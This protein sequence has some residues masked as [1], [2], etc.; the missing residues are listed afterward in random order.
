MKEGSPKMIKV[1]TVFGTRPEAIKLAPIVKILE[2]SPDTFS[3]VCCVTAQHREMLDQ[4]LN[5]FGVKP[6]YDL[7]I[8]KQGQSLTDVTVEVL[9]NVG[10][11]ISS[12][13]PDIV[14]VQGDTTTTFATSLAAFYQKIKI[15]HIEAGLRTFDKYQPFPEEI[16]RKLTA[17]LAD[18]HFAPT[19]RAKE[20][21]IK[22][23]IG[24]DRI[25]ITGNTGIDALF[26][27]LAQ[28]REGARKSTLPEGLLSGLGN[29][30]LILVTAHRR[31]NFGENIEEI[32]KALL[33]IVK[34]K[35]DV[36]IL[37][38]VHFNPNIRLT[39]KQCLRGQERIRLIDPLEYSAF[40]ELLGKAYLIL[41][42][43]GGVQE[44]APSL[45]K[46][47]LVL[48]NVTER[49]EAVEAG[50]VRLVGT[51]AKVIVREV[52]NLLDD[53]IEYARRSKIKNPFGD[54]HAS[55]R[56]IKEIQN[57]LS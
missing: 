19:T 3:S 21:L 31:E 48:R 4:A 34:R 17:A 55:Q 37:Y 35:H 44:E 28:I 22:E 18:Y 52:L 32:C 57:V 54:G 51:E 53:P 12:E 10:E 23:G 50:T 14:L 1:L 39:V 5:I 13:R 9:R 11:V 42:D 33:E 49:Q 29:K 24:G 27:T 25:F 2:G 41:T 46:P 6:K 26:L 56:I 45:G 40:V 20:N 47:V 36:V 8:M 30:R 15:G 7:A 43:S 38:P 16:N